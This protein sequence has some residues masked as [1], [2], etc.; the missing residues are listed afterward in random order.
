MARFI[1][2][3]TSLY[4]VPYLWGGKDPE[5]DGGLDCSGVVTYALVHADGPD[6]R[7]THNAQRLFDELDFLAALPQYSGDLV[8]YG[9]KGK[10]DHVMIHIGS[11]SVLGACDGN[12]TTTSVAIAKQQGASVKTRDHWRYRNGCMGFR[13]IPFLKPCEDM[14]DAIV[15]D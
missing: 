13:R 3:Y 8:F 14:S 4:G 10:V 12:H 9:R 6:L 11:G 7:Q 1:T 5:K 2:G 15:R